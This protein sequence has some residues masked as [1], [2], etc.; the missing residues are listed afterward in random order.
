[1]KK[2]ITLV[3]FLAAGLLLTTNVNAMTESELKDKLTDTYKVNGRTEKVDSAIETQIERYLNENE[4]SSEDCDYISSKIDEAIALIE[5]GS[6]TEW[7]ELSSKEMES[8]IAIV[9]DISS[10][11]SVKAAL[12]K[13]GVLT[14]YNED[15]TV[16]T[17]L[18]NLIKYTDNSIL[19]YLV[20]G[21]MSIVGLLLITRKIMKAN[22]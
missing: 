20:I 2:K 19:G 8:L 7:R 18:T 1:M 10:K 11:T 12:S 3:L 15:G 5:K 4:V 16:F 9:D 14:I 22:A 6:A 17:K 21:T 13:G